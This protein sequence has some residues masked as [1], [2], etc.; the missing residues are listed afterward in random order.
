MTTTKKMTKKDYFSILR[1]SYPADAPNYDEVIAFIDHEVELL[2]RKHSTN[3]GEKKL[4]ANQQANA[5]LKVDILSE[6][7]DGKLY[8]ISDMLKELPC[9]SGLSNQKVSAIVRQMVAP[10]GDGTIT[11]I[12]EKRTSFFCKA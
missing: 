9:C 11:K 1:E 12:E 3:S 10:I 2:D 6:M 5:E 8:T 7:E 4:T